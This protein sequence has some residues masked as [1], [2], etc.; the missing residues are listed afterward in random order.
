MRGLRTNHEEPS[1][2]LRGSAQG[3]RNSGVLARRDF[4]DGRGRCPVREPD[5][6]P[7]PEQIQALKTYA[8][9][10]GHNWKAAL[11]QAWMTGDYEGIERYGDTAAYLQQLRNTF[12]PS[13]L[14]RFVITPDA[15]TV[16]ETR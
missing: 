7:T 14:V 13:W 11:R 6:I 9:V 5:Q 15:W 1:V 12:G 2:R 8:Q 16:M 3:W 4:R 10:L